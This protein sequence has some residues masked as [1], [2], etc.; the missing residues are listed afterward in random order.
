MYHDLAM[1][2]TNLKRAVLSFVSLTL[3]AE[4]VVVEPH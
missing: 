2:A 3:Y 1:K 4:A